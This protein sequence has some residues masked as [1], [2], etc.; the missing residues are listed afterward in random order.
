MVSTC[1]LISNSSSL[2]VLFRVLRLPSGFQLLQSLYQA[3]G[4]RTKLSACPPVSSSSRPFSKLLGIIMIILLIWEFFTLVVADD[5]PLESQWQQVS[6]IFRTIL[7]ILA[8]LNNA[9]VW[10]VSTRLLISK[11]FSPCTNPLGSI[12]SVPITISINIPL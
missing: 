3:F 1:P 11:S 4:Y 8:D 5:F 10:M 6:S 12:P 9:L 7:S 2:W